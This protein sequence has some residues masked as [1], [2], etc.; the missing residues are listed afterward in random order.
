M[1]ILLECLERDDFS[2]SSVTEVIG[3]MEPMRRDQNR[4]RALRDAFLTQMSDDELDEVFE[5]WSRTE[6]TE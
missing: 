1:P 5:V 2:G 3:M 4:A 6:V